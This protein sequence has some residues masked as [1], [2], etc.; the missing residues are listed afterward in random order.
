MRQIRPTQTRSLISQ[1][2][3]AQQAGDSG[4]HPSSL[5]LQVAVALGAVAVPVAVFEPDLDVALAVT[6]AAVLEAQASGKLEQLIQLQS[7]M[8]QAAPHVSQVQSLGQSEA[9][10]GRRSRRSVLRKVPGT[11]FTSTTEAIIV[12]VKEDKTRAK[13]R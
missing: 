5:Q 8:S 7:V 11:R 2:P 4:V 3:L 13:M 9:W 6:D 10:R 12:A 1:V